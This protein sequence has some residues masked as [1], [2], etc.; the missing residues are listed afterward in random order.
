MT[1]QEFKIEESEIW[2]E[3][4]L[5]TQYLIS[6]LGMVRSKDKIVKHNHGGFATKKGRIMTLTDNGSGY[7]SVG[8]TENGKTKTTRV[9]RLVAITFIDNI[10][11]KPQVNHINGDKKDNRVENLEWNTCGENVMHAWNNNLA[12]KQSSFI[13]IKERLDKITPYINNRIR[14]KTPIGFGAIIIDQNCY[15]IE[16]DNGN[17]DNLVKSLR[18]WGDDFKLVLRNLS[19]LTKEIEHNGEKFVPI[20]KLA[21]LFHLQMYQF[22]DCKF[23]DNN[24]GRFSSIEEMPF[25]LIKQLIEWHFDVC[26]LIESG[27]AIDVNSL[28]IKPY[29]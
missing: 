5:N 12:K 18:F 2:K 7:L 3:F 22:I 27:E 16:Y 8:L 19:D 20:V 13:Y 10:E 21:S 29:K 23:Y 11:N 14:V 17:M 6:N 26:S 4:P 15:R 9:S 1:K 24:Y 28:E 25:N